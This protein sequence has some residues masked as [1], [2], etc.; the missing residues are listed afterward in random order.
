MT[1]SAGWRP[2]VL[3]RES[4]RNLVAHRVH[5]ATLAV[6][7][8]A[9]GFAVV[10]ATTSQVTD[11]Q[12]RFDTLVGKGQNVLV[13]TADQ[14]GY[15]SG[16]ECEAIGTVSGVDGA[17]GLTPTSTARSSLVPSL[18]VPVMT[19]T[20][21]VAPIIYPGVE[22]RRMPGTA[23]TGSWLSQQLGL[24]S[25]AHLALASAT[26]G[27]TVTIGSTA[28]ASPRNAAYDS[29]VLEIER[30]DIPVTSCL[31]E[32]APG[33]ESAV[34][35]VLAAG[36]FNTDAETFV[37][38]YWVDTSTGL[39]PQDELA[40]RVTAHFPWLGG[41][42]L[43]ILYLALALSRRAE[44]SLYRLLGVSTVGTA[45]QVTTEVVC[46]ALLPLHLGVLGAVLAGQHDLHGVTLALA[47][48]DYVRLVAV[49]L[50]TPLA[51][52]LALARVG[53]LDAFKGA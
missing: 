48:G 50:L 27:T 22:Q 42:V 18:S 47:Q 7:S 26:G 24:V 36:W 1:R 5:T 4:I 39:T 20:P 34:A 16:S 2:A 15:L 37:N 29:R 49:V 35:A 46:V 13:V 25:G 41:T 6:L 9:I 12:G 33:S 10:C 38:P 53:I 32:T 43:G 8:A 11:I 28:P 31:V 3:V 52:A 51:A 40:E 45:L 14:G 19:G 23:V 17:G 44:Y 21:G 30:P